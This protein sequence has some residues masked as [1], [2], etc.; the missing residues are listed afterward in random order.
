MKNTNQNKTKA[1]IIANTKT[2]ITTLKSFYALQ[3]KIWSKLE[4][5]NYV[6]MCAVPSSLVSSI[7]KESYRAMVVGAQ[8]FEALDNGAHTG[9][10]TLENIIEAG[11]RFVIVGHSEERTVLEDDNRINEKVVKSI[12]KNFTTVLCVGEKSRNAEQDYTEQIKIQII[13]DLK[14][15]DKSNISKLIIAYEPLWAIGA[16]KAATPVE[17]QEAIIIIRRTLVDV[18]GID[19]AKKIKV[20]YGGSVDH[21]NAR[22][23]ITDATADG[24]LVGRACMDAGKFAGIVNSLLN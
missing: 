13:K 1:I 10:N 22:K 16:A 5:D 3:N 21:D 19:N 4:K 7:A 8:S 6:Y 20:I 2:Y 18:F 11:A 17:A 9:Q 23:F 12:S 14:N 24:V 15:I